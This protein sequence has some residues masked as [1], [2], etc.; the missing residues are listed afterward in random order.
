[1]D[2]VINNLDFFILS[3]NLCFETDADNMAVMFQCIVFFLA[4]AWH[5]HNFNEMQYYK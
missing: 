5:C 4:T 2:V 1:M 3:L